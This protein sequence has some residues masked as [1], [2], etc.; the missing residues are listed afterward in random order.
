MPEFHIDVEQNNRM[1]EDEKRKIRIT[2][3]VKVHLYKMG[4]CQ[5]KH[6]VVEAFLRDSRGKIKLPV[7]RMQQVQE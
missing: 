4:L 2:D 5:K 7:L 3:E 1:I 6:K